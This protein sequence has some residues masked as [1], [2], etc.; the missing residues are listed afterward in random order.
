MDFNTSVVV[1]CECGLR[2]MR[3]AVPSLHAEIGHYKC[4]C[5]AVIGTWSDKY[6]LVFEPEEDPSPS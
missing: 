6:R 2:Y 3:T 5:G 4:I 1:D